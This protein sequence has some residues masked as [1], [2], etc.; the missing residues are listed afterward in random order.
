MSMSYDF[1]KARAREAAEAAAKTS[2]DNVR[3]RELRSAAAWLEMA[4]REQMVTRAREK[5]RIE[6]ETAIAAA[7]LLAD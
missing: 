2:L 5:A 4:E 1:C 3:D 6:K 7:A